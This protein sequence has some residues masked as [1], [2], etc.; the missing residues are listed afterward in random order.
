MEDNDQATVAEE[1]TASS[2]S[3]NSP[4]RPS[5][6]TYSPNRANHSMV[7][8]RRGTAISESSP[9]HP[10]KPSTSIDSATSSSLEVFG[11]VVTPS[12]IGIRR[13][14]SLQQKD[15]EDRSCK[16]TM[17][18]TADEALCDYEPCSKLLKAESPGEACMS[19]SKAY[20]FIY[21]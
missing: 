12:R 20:I 4:N 13:R 5:T 21:S 6:P 14:H 3:A 11:D 7:L 10:N 15:E 9:L 1:S 17:A 19:P 2:I 8:R 16:S 18:A